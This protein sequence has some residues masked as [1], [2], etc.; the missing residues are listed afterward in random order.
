[1]LKGAGSIAISQ[2]EGNA[3]SEG[4]V[5]GPME[6]QAL[7]EAEINARVDDVEKERLEGDCKRPGSS[8]ASRRTSGRPASF[9]S[10]S[11][12]S[13]C[14]GL[15]PRSGPLGNLRSSYT[16]PLTRKLVKYC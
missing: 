14:N 6:W 13:K 2:E 11:N 15:T 12:Q 10:L 9:P 4:C 5:A 8:A 7:E 1:M 3:S 16:D